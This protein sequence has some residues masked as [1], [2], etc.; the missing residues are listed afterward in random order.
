MKKYKILIIN[1]KKRDDRKKNMIKL[2][3]KYE[4]HDYHFYEAFDGKKLE[5]TLE[6]INLFKGNDFF[7]RKGIIGCALSH[8]NIWLDLI[9]DFENDYYLI[10]EDDIRISQNYNKYF[11]KIQ[12]Y[13][14]NN[15]VDILF[16]GYSSRN[17]NMDEYIIHE[18]THYEHII[19][20]LNINNYLGGFF[21]YIITK[22]G[23]MKMIDYINTNGIKHGIDYLIKINENLNLKVINPLIIFTD[24]VKDINDNIDSNIQKDY[25]IFNFNEIYDYNNYYFIKG[26]DIKDNDLHFIS[27]NNINSLI[28]ECNKNEDSSGFNTVGFLKKRSHENLFV[29]SIYFKKENDGIYIKLNRFIKIKIIG[30]YWSNPLDLCKEFNVMS[31]KNGEWNNI[32]IIHE[33]NDVD[34]YVIINK[35]YDNSYYNQE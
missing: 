19:E 18:D 30:N 29:D 24:W 2:F 5:L 21:S 26:K 4:I 6:I 33:D 17:N 15:D 28:N 20:D 13:I 22:K 35:P 3:H 1:L 12:E 8:Y 34:Y 23:A 7:N 11:E 14:N 27:P 31:K 16:L 9:T 25:D 10:F 32:K